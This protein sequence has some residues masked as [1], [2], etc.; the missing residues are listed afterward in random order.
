MY[1]RC[2]IPSVVEEDTSLIRVLR[3]RRTKEY[4][5]RVDCVTI[6]APVCG[7]ICPSAFFGFHRVEYAAMYVAEM[8]VPNCSILLPNDTWQLTDCTFEVDDEDHLYTL[9]FRSY[10]RTPTQPHTTSVSCQLHRLKPANSSAYPENSETRSTPTTSC[11]T[12]A[13]FISQRQTHC[14]AQTVRQSISRLFTP[15]SRLH[16]KRKSCL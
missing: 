12:M 9:M 13:T 11:R 10:P 1:R 6:Q 14:H 5:T 16:T 15:V 8:L 2:I 3:V 7:H 4:T